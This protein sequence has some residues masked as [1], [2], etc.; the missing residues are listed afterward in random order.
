MN[1]T[2]AGLI[3]EMISNKYALALSSLP[4]VLDTFAP[5]GSAVVS[6]STGCDSFPYVKS[7]ALTMNMTVLFDCVHIVDP[8]AGVGGTN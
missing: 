1:V 6:I 7:W 3:P 2:D 4:V 5:I 8:A